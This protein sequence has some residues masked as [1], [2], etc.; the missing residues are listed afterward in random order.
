MVRSLSGWRS[1]V[2]PPHRRDASHLT[3]TPP[4][5]ESIK[6]KVDFRHLRLQAQALLRH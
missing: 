5:T 2:A 1:E 4:A 6:S 3:M